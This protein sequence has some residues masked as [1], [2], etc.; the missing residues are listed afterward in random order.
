MFQNTIIEIGGYDGNDTLRYSNLSNTFVYCFEADIDMFK[1]LKTKFKNKTNVKVINKAVGIYDGVI[2]FYIAEN[3]MSS[4]INKLSDYSIQN[5]VT[6][7]VN[8]IQVESIRLDTFIQK[9][10]ITNIQYLHCDAQGSDFNILK[11]LGDKISII[12]NGQVEG[13][14]NNDLYD[15]DNHYTSIIEYLENN[16]FIILNKEEIEKRSNWLDLNIFFR[17]KKTQSIL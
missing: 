17:N 13:S 11:S 12:H 9:N 2:P 4:S 7:F 16:N 14:R 3:K 6:K 5:N 15:S 10:N 1:L 8:V